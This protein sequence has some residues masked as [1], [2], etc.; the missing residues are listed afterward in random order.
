MGY[1]VKKR[2][3]YRIVDFT[4]NTLNRIGLISYDKMYDIIVKYDYKSYVTE[5]KFTKGV[6]IVN[7]KEMEVTLCQ[8]VKK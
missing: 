3:Y 7:G 6:K 8:T 5:Y 4:A 2:W 1:E